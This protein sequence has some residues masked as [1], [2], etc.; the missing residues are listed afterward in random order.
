MAGTGG[1]QGGQGGVGGGVL[2]DVGNPGGT[3]FGGTRGGFGGL[4]DFGG[5]LS[6]EN[7][8]VNFG[9]KAPIDYIKYLI[10]EDIYNL[11]GNSMINSAFE[12]AYMDITSFM[13]DEVLIENLSKTLDNSD[14]NKFYIECTDSTVS[15][16]YEDD[17]FLDNTRVLKVYRKTSTGET[18][19]SGGDE[20]QYFY[21]C[22]NR[23]QVPV[24]ALNPHSIFYENDPFNPIWTTK[25]NGGL[26]IY[27]RLENSGHTPLG[28]VYYLKYPKFGV[29][30]AESSYNTFNLGTSSGNSNLSLIPAQSEGAIF[31][32]IP[33]EARAAIYYVTAFNLCNGYLSNH[34]QDDEDVELVNL[35]TS[36][37]EL[38]VAR[39]NDEIKK[40]ISKFG[41][42]PESIG[43][44]Q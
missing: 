17:D 25:D 10:G 8:E 21:T 34:V 44:Q 4:G 43:P 24:E 11:F 12:E 27:P 39:K 15:I 33:I 37:L 30:V 7:M 42:G 13:T 28:K 36:Q 18:T 16:R 9:G 22:R 5:A 41:E 3:G 23:V 29:G 2:E 38:I 26:F 40:V 19:P 31:K 20:E 32:G 1:G 14:G 35:L 6:D